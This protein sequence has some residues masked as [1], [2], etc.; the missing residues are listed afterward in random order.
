MKHIFLFI[1]LI[2]G[3][4]MQSQDKT[5]PY[6]EIP[7]A[8]KKY[9]AGTMASRQIDGL[10]FR[11]YWATEGLNVDDLAYKPNDK[12]RST[13]ETIQHIFNLSQVI[14]SAALQKPVNKTDA[15]NMSAQDIRKNVLF[16][17][18]QAS[19]ILRKADDLS[20]FSI[21]FGDGKT[22]PFWNAINGP[23]ADAIWHCGQ[24]AS[25]RRTSGNPINSN[26]NQ[27]TGALRN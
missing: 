11:F 18:K 6:Y 7:E 15:S 26:I 14:L 9:T 12:A 4:T 13:K 10:G 3:S 23:I 21:D 27:F 8:P 19:D 2:L 1:A 5:L 17:L 25:Y 22:Y 24:I 20:D 16:N